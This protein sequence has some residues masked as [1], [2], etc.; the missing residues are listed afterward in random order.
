MTTDARN[1]GTHYQDRMHRILGACEACG[2]RRK[3][4]RQRYRD[5][6]VEQFETVLVQPIARDPVRAPANLPWEMYGLSVNPAMLP[7]VRGMAG[8][9]ALA[10]NVPSTV[11]QVDGDT[12]WVRVPTERK[13]TLDWQAA[14]DMAPD[15]PASHLLLGMDDEGQQMTLDLGANYHALVCGQT[16][17]GKS[18]LLRTMAISALVRN[19]PV[20]LLD[21]KPDL[22]PLSGHP[23]VWQGGHFESADDIETCLLYLAE[24]TRHNEQLPL[25]IFCDEARMLCDRPRVRTALADIT[26]TGRHIGMHLILGSQT[27]EG[28]VKEAVENTNARIVGRMADARRSAVATSRPGVGA[29]RS[30]G[31]GDFWASTTTTDEPVHFQAAMPSAEFMADWARRYPPRGGAVPEVP[32]AA[33]E[34]FTPTMDGTPGRR[35]DDLPPVVARRIADYYATHHKRPPRRTVRDWAGNDKDLDNDKWKR[36]LLAVLPSRVVYR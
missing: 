12:V 35:A 23:A 19:I 9:F 24:R 5:G 31:R 27:A 8:Q 4:E 18:T 28:V 25:V 13:A 34:H 32:K 3:V 11:V 1:A 26:R 14:Y 2:V 21:P 6:H 10:L 16:G 36:W 30:Q 33:T 22:A 17:S 7:K 15:L 29:E 20:A